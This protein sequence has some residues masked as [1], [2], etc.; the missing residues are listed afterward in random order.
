MTFHDLVSMARRLSNEDRIEVATL[1]WPPIGQCW[2][3]PG[4]PLDP[5]LF[6]AE[7]GRR[8]ADLDAGRS[9]TVNLEEFKQSMDAH[10][11]DHRARDSRRIPP[12]CTLGDP[13]LRDEIVAVVARMAA[14]DRR[15]FALGVWPD[16]A[17][18]EARY[19]RFRTG[20][21]ID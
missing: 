7:M 20:N 8:V 9:R 12:G 4:P 14:E 13:P 1:V 2:S 16:E 5:E 11:A 17:Y 6:R 10:M 21:E 3:I 19:G 18:W 15:H